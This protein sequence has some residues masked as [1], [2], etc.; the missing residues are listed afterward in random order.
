[1]SLQC[2]IVDFQCAMYFVY[3]IF[4]IHVSLKCR[5]GY[6]VLGILGILGVLYSLLA[7]L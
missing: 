5:N 1:M 7:L 3:G 4:G 2:Y 6:G